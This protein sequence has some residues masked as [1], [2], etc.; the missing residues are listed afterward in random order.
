MKQKLQ[1]AEELI[2]RLEKRCGAKGGAY[3]NGG[4]GYAETALIVSERVTVEM[5]VDW[6]DPNYGGYDDGGVYVI[7]VDKKGNRH[8]K[9]AIYLKTNNLEEIVG[10]L[11]EAFI[12]AV[13]GH[14]T[15]AG[16]LRY[17]PSKR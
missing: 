10:E 16:H 9:R 14:A 11:E 12:K 1:I 2:E 17:R 8:E 5:I 3:P 15:G 7:T 6:D 4:F 13:S